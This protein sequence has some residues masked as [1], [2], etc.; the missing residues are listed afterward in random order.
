VLEGERAEDEERIN[1]NLH[2]R[3]EYFLNNRAS[4]R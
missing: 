1:R 4:R 3:D 2:A